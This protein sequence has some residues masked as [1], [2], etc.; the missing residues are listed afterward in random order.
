MVA[1]HNRQS[2]D[3]LYRAKN[4][5]AEMSPDIEVMNNEKR[6]AAPDRALGWTR[7]VRNVAARHH[8]DPT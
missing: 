8:I 4:M 3:G 7:S 1:W 5:L 6:K 2:Q